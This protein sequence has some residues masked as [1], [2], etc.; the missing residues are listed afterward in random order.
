MVVINKVQMDLEKY[1]NVIYS[2]TYQRR[3]W[4]AYV[5]VRIK[6]LLKDWST[7]GAYYGAGWRVK[8]ES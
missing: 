3:L 8:K 2:N 7:S 4:V 1:T 5:K 6:A